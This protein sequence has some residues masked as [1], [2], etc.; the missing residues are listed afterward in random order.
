[1]YRI[2]ASDILI[3]TLLMK[4]NMSFCLM[5]ALSFAEFLQQHGVSS[6]HFKYVFPHCKQFAVPKC[7]GL[8]LYFWHNSSKHN[9]QCPRPRTLA[10]MSHAIFSLQFNCYIRNI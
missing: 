10:C 9:T 1:V 3:L 2:L 7:Y 4:K 5:L 8:A 6:G